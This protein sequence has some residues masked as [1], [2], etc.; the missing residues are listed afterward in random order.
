[1][2]TAFSDILAHARP[3]VVQLC[4]ELAVNELR[5]FGSATGDTF[6]A[7]AS[8]VDVVVDFRDHN[9]PGIADRYMSLAE[10]LEEIFC[11]PVDLV[12]TRSI[13][14]PYFQRAVE[15]TSLLIYAA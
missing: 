2:T 12:T 8:D 9:A 1:M 13:R 11:L 3:R 5:V 10:G 15:E 14:N 6:D 4:R 7:A